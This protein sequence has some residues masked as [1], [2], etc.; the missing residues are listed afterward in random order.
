MKIAV[1][2][3]SLQQ[4]P[5]CC[6]Q[7]RPTFHET[8]K[9]HAGLDIHLFIH[10]SF[11][12]GVDW[13]CCCVIWCKKPLK[14]K[15]IIISIPLLQRIRQIVTCAPSPAS[16]SLGCSLFRT[17]FHHHY[18]HLR[19]VRLTW[20]PSLPWIPSIYISLPLVPSPGVIVSVSCLCVVH[21]SCFVLCCVYLLKPSLP[22][23]A[24]RLSAH[25]VT[26]IMLTSA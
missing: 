18:A 1:L 22:E 17:P 23:L 2:S 20:N 8:E 19:V 6:V 16:R 15:C 24:S 26:Q 5:M 10:L 21:V 25:V 13:E 14:I 11:R 12:Q 3:F 7:C 4:Q 9:Q